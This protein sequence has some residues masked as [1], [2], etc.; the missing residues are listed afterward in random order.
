MPDVQYPKQANH[1]PLFPATER[2]KNGPC[3]ETCTAGRNVGG[4]GRPSVPLT[5]FNAYI[6]GQP[7]LSTLACLSSSYPVVRVVA[8]LLPCHPFVYSSTITCCCLSYHP[9]GRFLIAKLQHP[10]QQEQQT[11][12]TKNGDVGIVSWTATGVVGGRLP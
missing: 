10:L 4:I 8:A 1:T 9:L 12:V 7:L 2:K 5:Y 6:A 3:G 11:A